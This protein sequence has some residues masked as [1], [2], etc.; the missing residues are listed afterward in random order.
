MAVFG[1]LIG[2]ILVNASSPKAVEARTATIIVPSGDVGALYAAVYDEDGTPRDHVAIILEAGTYELDP[3]EPFEGRL[4]LGDRSVLKSTLI[5]EKDEDGVPIVSDNMPKVQQEGAIID[6]SALVLPP[7]TA[8]GLIVVGHKGSVEQL[9]IDGGTR[10]GLEI[11]GNGTARQVASTGHSIGFRVRAAGQK[12]KARL[13][14]CLAAGN[15]LFGIGVIALGPSMPHPTYGDVKVRATIDRTASV[16]NGM[17]NLLVYGGL[18]TDG[19]QVHAKVFDSVFR[20]SDTPATNVAAMGGIT[21]LERGGADNNQVKLGILDSTIAG[22]AT[23]LTAQ[24]GVTLPPYFD[25]E[26]PPDERRSSNNRV[27]VTISDTAFENNAT[28]IVAHGAASMVADEPYGD[29]NVVTVIVED[30]DA[31][32]LLCVVMPCFPDGDLADCTN[33]AKIIQDDD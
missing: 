3:S 18:G 24:G 10:P 17:W 19:S 21:Y 16:N 20:H 11:T 29:Y 4:V 26:V 9:W 28:D 22:G 27:K 31:T 32:D 13:E 15:F 33:K 5:M 2:I 30:D 8:E 1:L 25:P 23:G 6:G 7:P 12:A 14:G